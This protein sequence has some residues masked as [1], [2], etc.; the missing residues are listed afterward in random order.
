VPAALVPSPLASLSLLDLIPRIHEDW[1]SPYHLADWCALIERSIHGHVRAMCAVPFQHYKTSTTLMGVVWL[2][3]KNPKLRIILLTHSHEKAKAMGKDLRRLWEAAGGTFAKGFNTI[4]EWQTSEGGGCVV[5][6]AL[7]SK[8]GYPCDLLLVDDPLDETEYMLREVRDQVDKSIALYTARTATHLDSTLLVASRWHIDDP[9]GRRE[10]RK[11]MTW[12]SISHAG[13]LDFGLPTERAF[14]PEVLSL[15]QHHQMRREWAEQD[16]SLK[17]WWA[18]VQNE[19]QPD[20]LGLFRGS[21][22]G[23]PP[24][25][26]RYI[27]G[28]DLAYS[29]DVHADYF[30]LVVLKL[31]EGKA[32]VLNVLR[33]RRDLETAT[34]RIRE[35]MRIYP[36]AM[37]FSYISGPEKGS[38]QYLN[39][40][41]IPVQPIHA[42]TPKYVRAQKTIDAWNTGLI[43]LPEQ[44]PW[45]AGVLSRV[46]MFTGNEAAGDDDEIDALVSACDGGLFSAGAPPRTVGKWRITR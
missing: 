23:P 38:I 7:Q 45:M 28:I 17:I 36:G 10:L 2:L 4:D 42:R 1:T 43:V 24:A 31:W 21:V 29:E 30:A 15:A 12:E 6:S 9:Y 27:F 33:E 20:A 46:W 13:I 26:G 8:L 39:E 37:M 32:H 5:M 25:Y 14:A 16:P 19:P 3:L 11:E 34:T 44:A 41:S 40:R 35:A 18:Q 22:H